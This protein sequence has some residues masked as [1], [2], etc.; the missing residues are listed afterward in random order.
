MDS[1]ATKGAP[2]RKSPGVLTLTIGAHIDWVPVDQIVH[3]EGAGNYSRIHTQNGQVYLTAVIL[4][5]MEQRLP[6][7]RRVHKSHLINP[8]YVERVRKT[9]GSGR[10]VLLTTGGTVPIARRFEVQST[11]FPEHA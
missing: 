6:T 1:E 3:V 5:L 10:Y 9:E 7:F 2:G 4:R 8:D 11:I